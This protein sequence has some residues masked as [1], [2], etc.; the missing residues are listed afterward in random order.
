LIVQEITQIR[1][2]A[3]DTEAHDFLKAE[4]VRVSPG[5]KKRVGGLQQIRQPGKI[6]SHSMMM[7]AAERMKDALTLGEG[8]VLAREKL[9]Q[10]GIVGDAHDW[11]G[12]FKRKMQVAD[13]PA[14]ACGGGGIG[15][16]RDFEDGL[17]L[18]RDDVH[19]FVARKDGCMIGERSF[20]RETELPPVLGD[21]APAALREHKAI[22]R[23]AQRGKSAIPIRE[24][25][26]D[27]IQGDQKRK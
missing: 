7:P 1:L 17:I 2:I 20:Q 25:G 6:V 23:N 11:A 15:A 18:L 4:R 10:R 22:D 13:D 24:G 14:E 5:G 12:D 27:E 3:H 26:V 21:S 16:E 8:D 19:A 9:P